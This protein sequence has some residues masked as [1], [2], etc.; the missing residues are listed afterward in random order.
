MSE[1]LKIDTSRFGI[2][3]VP[4]SSVI[5]IV[6]GLIGFPS[7]RRYVMLDYNPPFSWLQSVDNKDL[8]FV[9]V[10]GAEFGESYRFA[11]PV[12]DRELDLG[13]TDEV[14][15]VNLIS[16]R[17]DPTMT[18]V[19][20]KAPII[21]NLRNMRARQIILDDQKFPTRFPLWSPEG[22]EKTT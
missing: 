14:A 13:E 7:I 20:L 19:N 18:T 15:I 9:V 22:K 5:D 4:S 3:E 2:I 11:L 1:K 8:A 12:G 6:Y 17:P 16:V 10:N 21:V